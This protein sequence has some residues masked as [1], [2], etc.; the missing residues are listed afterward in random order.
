[1]RLAIYGFGG[2][3]LEVLELAEAINSTKEYWSEIFFIDDNKRSDEHL[4]LSFE[5]FFSK[6]D[7]LRNE[8]EV[9][10]AVGEPTL[11]EDLYKKVEKLDLNFATLIHPMSIISK[12]STIGKGVIVG[13]S[14]SISHSVVISD[15]VFIQPNVIIGHD[16]VINRNSIVSPG[17]S[18]GG[19][20]QIGKTVFIGFNSSIIQNCHIGDNSIVGMGSSV[21][22]NVP[23]S[24]LV[25]GN[26]AKIISTSNNR[27]VF[28]GVKVNES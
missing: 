26:P 22:M 4:T 17:V 7:S 27:R 23:E 19:N 12:K 6:K 18:V 8:V 20:V 1:M 11:R 24:S 16:T 25:V 5:E 13:F 28:S 10:I 2:L 14:S 9:V 15:N 3:G 21:N